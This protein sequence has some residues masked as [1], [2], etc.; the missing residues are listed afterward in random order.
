MN[1]I[2]KKFIVIVT[3]LLLSFSFALPI[4]ATPVSVAKQ[5]QTETTNKETKKSKKPTYTETL[6]KINKRFEDEEKAEKTK[7]LKDNTAKGL[8]KGI[9]SLFTFATAMQDDNPDVAG[10]M[11]DL[12]ISAVNIVASC[13]GLG[14]VSD[15]ILNGVVSLAKSGNEAETETQKLQNHIDEK[16]DEVNNN[17]DELQEDISELSIHVDKQTQEI[18][19]ALSG[20]FAAQTAKEEIIKFVSSSDGNF[21]Y[22]MFKNYLHGSSD[23]NENPYYDKAYGFILQEAAA[24]NPDDLSQLKD[25]YDAIYTALCSEHPISGLSNIQMLY[26]YM[27]TDST[28]VKL[29]IQRYYYDYLSENREFIPEQDV[30]GEAVDFALDLYNTLI[31]AQN[32]VDLCLLNQQ[33]YLLQQYGEAITDET[34]YYYNEDEYITYGEITTKLNATRNVSLEAVEAQLVKD[35]AYII[36]I[37]SAFS[38][39]LSDETYRTMTNADMET[40][41]QVLIGQTIYLNKF[42]QRICKAFDLNEDLFTYEWSYGDFVFSSNDG[43][44]SVPEQYSEFTGTV[45]YNQKTVYSIDFHVGNEST[46][47]GGSGS[48]DDPYIIS[49]AEQF[50]S[51]GSLKNGLSNHYIILNDID[52]DNAEL[53]AFGN[54]LDEDEFFTGSIDGRGHTLS[55]FTIKDSDTAALFECI[56]GSGTVKNLKFDS[57]KIEIDNTGESN[58]K[59]QAGVVAAVNHGTISNCHIANCEIKIKQEVYIV[60]KSISAYSGGIAGISSGTISNCSVKNSSVSAI[61]GRNYKANDD[62]SNASSVYAGGIA[63]LIDGGTVSNVVVSGVSLKSAGLSYAE[64]NA[65]TVYPYVHVYAGGIAAQSYSGNVSN[66]FSSVSID[67]CEFLADN[68]GT[69]MCYCNTK[70]SFAKNSNYIPD[71]TISEDEISKDEAS[72]VFPSNVASFDINYSF[73]CDYDKDLGY[74]VDQIYES[75][76]STLKLENLSI[77]IGD[78]KDV[79]YSIVSYFFDSKNSSKTSKKT[80]TAKILFVT[81]IDGQTTAGT[82]ELPVLIKENKPTGLVLNVLPNQLIYGK[83]DTVSTLGGE[84]LLMY[85]DGSSINV[86]RNVQIPADATAEFGT[87][88]ITAT[89]DDFKVEFEITVVC[90]YYLE[91]N[92]V[93]NYSSKT[94]PPTCSSFGYTVTICND[95]G[96]YQKN[97]FVDKLEH[98]LILHNEFASSCTIPGYSG[99]IFCT[100]CETIVSKGTELPIT[101]HNY[102]DVD[103]ITIHQCKDCGAIEEH[104]FSA[105][106]TEGAIIYT[107]IICDSVYKE[108]QSLAESTPR[109]VVGESYALLDGNQYITVYVQMINNPGITGVSFSVNYDERLELI[110]HAAS[111]VLN[112]I[113]SYNPHAERSSCYFTMARAQVD[114]NDGNMLKLVFKVPDDATL[115]EKYDISISFSRSGVQFSD[116]NNNPVYIS[117]VPGGITVVSHLPGDVNNDGSVDILDSVLIARYL[118]NYNDS[119]FNLNYADVDLNGSVNI[120]D[121]TRLLQ[122]LVGGYD[123]NLLSNQYDIV[124]NPNDDSTELGS[125]TVECFDENNN[126][127]TYGAL[128]TLSRDGYTFD[129][130]YTAFVGGEKITADSLVSYNY[131]QPKQTLY[132]HWTPNSITFDGNGATSGVMNQV[133]YAGGNSLFT[134]SNNFSK[135]TT[136]Y[137]YSL[138][139]DSQNTHR[140]VNQEFLGWSLSKDSK[141]IAYSVGDTIDLKNGNIG[142]LTLYAVWSNVS[143]EMPVYQK[144]GSVLAGWQLTTF[145]DNMISSIDTDHLENGT[146]VYAKWAAI[147][148]VVVYDGNGATGGSTIDTQVS[149]DINTELPLAINGFYR[150]GSTFVGW[151]TKPDGTGDSYSDQE[152]VN[153]IAS[154]KDGVA[155]LYA[156]WELIKYNITYHYNDPNVA[157]SETVEHTIESIDENCIS[158]SSYSEYNHFIGWYKDSAFTQK[159]SVD[160]FKASPS[161]INL[162]AKWDL[163]KVYNYYKTS[164]D[165]DPNVAGT[166][167]FVYDWSSIKSNDNCNYHNDVLNDYVGGNR[168][169]DISAGTTEV[170]FIG[171]EDVTYYDLFIYL[172]CFKSYSNIKIHFINFNFKGFITAWEHPS[173]LNVTL[174]IKGTCTIS[175]TDSSRPAIGWFSNLT[176]EGSYD[177]DEK[178]KLI[179]YGYDGKGGSSLGAS[180]ENG[181]CAI[182]ASYLTIN[183]KGEIYAYGG[184]GGDGAS[185]ADGGTDCNGDSGGNGGNGAHAIVASRLTTSSATKIHAE[186]GNGGKGGDGGDGGNGANGSAH[187]TNS[188]VRRG[189]DGGK[190]GNG[191]SGGYGGYGIYLDSQSSLNLSNSGSYIRGGNSGK[192]GNG[193]DGGDGGKGGDGFGAQNNGRGGSGG[194]AGSAGWTPSAS[195]SSNI[196][197]TGCT[198]SYGSTAENAFNGS[199]GSNGANGSGGWYT[200]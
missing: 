163:V 14:D 146:Y 25:E 153:Y 196:S 135:S 104:Q 81:T 15:S 176:I 55:N 88:L 7:K 63:A 44:L 127:K 109:V 165:T 119:S 112:T 124:L 200:D 188:S 180:G 126:R 26:E 92:G 65:A 116:K 51:I 78:H 189:H 100:K 132:A 191:G 91:H 20:A 41:G 192:G 98:D 2:L 169:L 138:V 130:W 151:N 54:A 143:F 149:R 35:I 179:V 18:L 161:N 9:S 110:S 99:D 123:A 125:T 120:N 156:Q 195:A 178:G 174:D 115:L 128:P 31:K 122:N 101:P 67:R 61:S 136:I 164:P 113:S 83:G 173:I 155:T 121:L 37:E 5:T 86:T 168:N 170:Y 76:E 150:S 68:V 82:L 3:A 72:I 11:I 40:Y 147:E 56:G 167:R 8:S 84:I 16:F 197:I 158:Y 46:Y 181:N 96:F 39:Q 1:S 28:G 129:G 70:N 93:H 74:Y 177:D 157:P 162:Y 144:N 13:F 42:P 43:K 142:N 29:S 102:E 187:K 90:A 137:I 32:M 36:G 6:Q 23:I 152:S 52:F 194:A 66:V 145:G 62:K 34:R 17:I 33:L 134:L 183:L 95:C 48:K 139:S 186:G 184:D 103:N 80:T 57:I 133:S 111:D 60:N 10:A 94:V 47:N 49:T 140:T 175:A 58:P 12:T 118:S 141:E 97:A 69:F 38:L 22:T 4:V 89:Y 75:G 53:S 27:Q 19:S 87:K 199:A 117:T 77:D 193:G 85:G 106:E 59:A 30:E 171:S 198:V 182:N 50:K 154:E 24:K 190:G 172:A 159:F 45:L 71:T 105:T 148:Y 64:K 185:G 114:Y 79:E 160:E 131:N 107:C 21:S 73:T 166:T 108:S